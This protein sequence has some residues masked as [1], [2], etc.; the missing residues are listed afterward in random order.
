[1]GA[2]GGGWTTLLAA[3]LDP[4]ITTS[5]SVAGSLPIP[6]RTGLCG[7]AS[8]G[9]G[10]QQNQPG[11]L[12]TKIS[13]L[14]LYIMASNGRSNGLA[15]QHIQVNNQYDTCCYFGVTHRTYSDM[16]EN[17]VNQTRL[18]RYH[19]VL[20]THFVG[21]GYDSKTTPPAANNT[22]ND[23]VLPAITPGPG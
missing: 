21:H 22:L 16:L 6:L 23:V 12:Y 13:Y 14:D 17:Y 4:R 9:D 3:A 7:R 5:V 11:L 15:R 19:Y 8:V 1:M 10:E 18:G 20:N 2:S